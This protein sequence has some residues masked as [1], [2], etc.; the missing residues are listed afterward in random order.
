[1]KLRLD[2]FAKAF[3]LRVERTLTEADARVLVAGV[4][5]LRGMDRKCILIDLSE[6]LPCARAL[7]TMRAYAGSARGEKDAV[8]RLVWAGPLREFCE[9]ESPEEF[10]EREGSHEAREIAAMIDLENRVTDLTR[11]TEAR[12]LVADRLGESP[13][14]HALEAMEKEF[15]AMNRGLRAAQTLIINRFLDPVFSE[16]WHEP[17]ASEEDA[18]RFEAHLL[19]GTPEDAGDPAETERGA[20]EPAAD[21]YRACDLAKVV[22][23][24]HGRLRELQAETRRKFMGGKA[25]RVVSLVLEN[26]TTRRR[27]SEIKEAWIASLERDVAMTESDFSAGYGPL[28]ESIQAAEEERKKRSAA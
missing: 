6:A 5:K 11:L 23:D 1:M 16:L 28:L 24:L 14:S 12:A 3:V 9:F 25:D 21:P 27:I 8:A 4:Q 18:T 15:S 20:A 10:F 22:A 17:P 19:G 26:G 7:E 2:S 13:A